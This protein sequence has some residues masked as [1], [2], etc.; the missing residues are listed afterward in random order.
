MRRTIIPLI[1]GRTRYVDVCRNCG[2]Q[3]TEVRSATGA[4]LRWRFDGKK[5][6]VV[7]GSVSV[8]V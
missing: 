7:A 2:L 1:A 4:L 8:G 3:T 5:P 6:S